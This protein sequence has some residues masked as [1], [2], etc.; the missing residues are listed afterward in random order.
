MPTIDWNRNT[1]N[2]EYNWSEGGGEWSRAWGGEDMHW[3]GSIL[4]RIH[5][6]IPVGTMLEIAPGFGRW[7]QFL[8]DLCER[9]I[10]VD[11][12]DKCIQVCQER[13]KLN[14]HISYFVN[15]GSSL[16]MI[17][18]ESVDFIF[19][20]DSLVHVEDEVIQK[21]IYQF[22]RILT[23]DGVGFIHH[24][25]LGEYTKYFSFVRWLQKYFVR[26]S[27]SE[28]RNRDEQGSSGLSTI[29]LKMAQ[30]LVEFGIIDKSHSRAISMTASKFE[31]YTKEA[32]LQCISQEIIDWGSKRLI[33]C[34]SV[35]TKTDSRW[36]RE[37]KFI[38]NDHYMKEAKNIFA[39]SR[40]YGRSSFKDH[41]A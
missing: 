3:Y 19:S 24:S 38:R 30:A 33:D 25:N 8:R 11:L 41:H 5:C 18:D 35:F 31:E 26:P 12:S 10:L 34:L 23:K 16:D 37:S 21:Y 9:L 27:H 40:L 6:F 7:T 2:F 29:K 32:G 1:W 22:S 4:P 20:F 39:A 36:S 17:D 15:D 14:S 28:D 13:F